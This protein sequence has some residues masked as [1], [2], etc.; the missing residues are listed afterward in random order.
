M[1]FLIKSAF[2]LAIVFSYMTWP[3]GERPEAIARQAAGELAV[4]AQTAV[5]EKTSSACA[6]APADCFNAAGR[7]IALAQTIAPPK[8]PD[9]AKVHN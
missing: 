5:A 8:K 3:G 2:W 1:F 6:A 9:R 4:R 7:A